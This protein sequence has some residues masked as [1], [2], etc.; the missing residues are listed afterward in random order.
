MITDGIVIWDG[1]YDTPLICTLAR[2]RSK[3][4]FQLGMLSR[5]QTLA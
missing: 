3:A 2:A 4:P 1:A 5:L